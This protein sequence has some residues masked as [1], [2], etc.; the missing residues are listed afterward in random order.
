MYL[1]QILLATFFKFVVANSGYFIIRS[2]N[3]YSLMLLSNIHFFYIQGHVFCEQTMY[4]QLPNYHDCLSRQCS[5]IN[6]II[7]KGEA[8]K[9]DMRYFVRCLG[10][11]V[12]KGNPQESFYNIMLAKKVT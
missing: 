6:F 12:A 10:I 9:V 4:E 8:M 2:Y 7:S 11:N 5:Y 1:V 3:K